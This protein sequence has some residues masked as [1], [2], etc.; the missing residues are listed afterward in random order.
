MGLVAL[1]VECAVELWIGGLAINSSSTENGFVVF[2][3]SWEL[4]PRS[5][6]KRSVSDSPPLREIMSFSKSSFGE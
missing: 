1:I 4:T 3:S 5:G 6:P 2:I